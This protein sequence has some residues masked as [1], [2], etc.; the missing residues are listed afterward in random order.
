MTTTI[1]L[2]PSSVSAVKE[3]ES[4]TGLVS[5]PGRSKVKVLTKPMIRG[6]RRSVPW[7]TLLRGVNPCEPELPAPRHVVAHVDL[8][9]YGIAV[10]HAHGID[11]LINE[12]HI[13]PR[14]LGAAF[15]AARA[16][17][18]SSGEPIA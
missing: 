11:M 7:L 17:A 1:Y 18:I 15:H 9:L 5:T 3:I 2:H 8:Q 6:P 14:A 12:A 4:D 13:A 10:D 16:S